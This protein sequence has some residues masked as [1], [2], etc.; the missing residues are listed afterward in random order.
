MYFWLKEIGIDGISIIGGHKGEQRARL[1]L[2]Y[3][4]LTT[5]LSATQ[6]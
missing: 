6:H 5:A 1:C 2:S 3:T 4:D